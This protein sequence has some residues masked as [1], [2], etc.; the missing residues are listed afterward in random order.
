MRIFIQ[1]GR[2]ENFEVMR[3]KSDVNYPF[4][5]LRFLWVVF[6]FK[7]IYTCTTGHLG[8]KYCLCFLDV[9]RECI[10]FDFISRDPA[11]QNLAYFHRL[12]G[13]QFIS[14]IYVF[15]KHLLL[16][17]LV[18][19]IVVYNLIGIYYLLVANIG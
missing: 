5:T 11:Q 10:S 6:K 12:F 18:L 1:I 15:N 4:K 14:F 3:L 2:M 17:S 9:S 8:P 13:L 19:K 16:S 7:H